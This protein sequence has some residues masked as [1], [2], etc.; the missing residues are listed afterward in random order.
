MNAD[1]AS[2]FNT[3]SPCPPAVSKVTLK[4]C[5]SLLFVLDPEAAAT[6]VATGVHACPSSDCSG[7]IR[8]GAPHGP[9]PYGSSVV[10]PTR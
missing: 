9:D 3:N 10:A 4:E 6:R 1:R 5:P 2:G 7:L 8:P